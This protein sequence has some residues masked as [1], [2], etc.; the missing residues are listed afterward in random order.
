MSQFERS[1][2]ITSTGVGVLLFAFSSFLFVLLIFSNTWTFLNQQIMRVFNLAFPNIKFLRRDKERLHW[3]LQ[4]VVGGAV[5]AAV[6]Y[7][8]SQAAAFLLELLGSLVSKN[9]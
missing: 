1:T 9:A 2:H 8:L 7:V 4:A 6:L 5:G 3:L